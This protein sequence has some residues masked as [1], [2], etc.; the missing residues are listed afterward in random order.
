MFDYYFLGFIQLVIGLFFTF[1][2]PKKPN[3]MYGYWGKAA[4]RSL[5]HWKTAHRTAGPLFILSGLSAL[6]GGYYFEGS[7]F[8]Y[9]RLVN[10][11][12]G[13]GFGIVVI[14]ITE[15]KLKGLNS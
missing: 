4:K 2:P 14:L 7:A 13:F 12:I 8:E 6:A 1:S 10:L 5:D 9:A 3:D 11:F 15:R